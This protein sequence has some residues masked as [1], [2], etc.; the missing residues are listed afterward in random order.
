MSV[1]QCPDRAADP[2][3]A[4]ASLT[5]GLENAVIRR[6]SQPTAAPSAPAAAV[7]PSA[8]AAPEAATALRYDQMLERVRYEGMYPTRERAEATV[9]TVLTV[10]GQ[11]LTGQERLDLVTRLPVEA[12]RAL[13]AEA[14]CG[15]AVAARDLV[16]RIAARTGGTN[17]TARWDAGTVLVQIARLV[18]DDV[19]D[20]LL[21][22]LPS[23]YA[24]LFGRAELIQP[25]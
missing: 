16:S 11:Q 14:P 1:S 24:L 17:A 13:A 5:A 7:V 4:G 25:A 8:P 21:A 18:G 23:G 3:A 19:L 20:R 2:V 6:P 22:R 12:A 9:R 15:E 10:L